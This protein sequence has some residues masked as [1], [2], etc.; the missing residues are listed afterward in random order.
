MIRFEIIKLT[1]VDLVG[2]AGS[3]GA[4]LVQIKE[5]GYSNELKQ[6]CSLVLTELTAELEKRECHDE[7]EFLLDT[8]QRLEKDKSITKRLRENLAND[9]DIDI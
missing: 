2:L 3:V 8:L 7:L 6:Q 4:M 9:L 5:C 1:N